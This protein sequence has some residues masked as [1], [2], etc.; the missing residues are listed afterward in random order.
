MGIINVTPDSF[1]GDGL[2]MD[3]A[4]AV[5]R[6]VA[7][8]AAGAAYVDIGGESTR[9]YSA[10]VPE[11]V[12]LE[13]VRGVVSRLSD[14]YPGRVSVDT[15]KPGVAEAALA[16]GAAI[17]NDVSGLRSPEMI[18]T[19]AR[20]HATV[21]IMHMLG[22]PRTMQ[23]SPQYDDVVREVSDYLSDRIAHAEQAG[24]EP[25]NIMIDPGIGFGKTVDHNIELLRRL[26][27]FK[28]LG[29]PVV[30]GASRKSFIGAVAGGT[31]DERLGGSIA[32]AVIAASNGADV[33]RTHDVPETVQ[34]LRVARRVGL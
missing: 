9:P 33:I 14:L 16:A 27:E 1:S 13:R 22:D 30:I 28:S 19:V 7:I 31:V 2:D 32:A 17:V 23:D 21:I 24:V 20:H 6:G 26:R 8:F 4:A 18:A 15:T 10:A 3:E 25:R 29:K 34:A 12:E 11:Q 5:E